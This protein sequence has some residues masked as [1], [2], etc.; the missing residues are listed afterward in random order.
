MGWSG[1]SLVKRDTMTAV[2][3]NLF[4][5]SCS[6][7]TWKDVIGCEEL[8]MKPATP[9]ILTFRLER[10]RCRPCASHSDTKD[11]VEPE[12]RI[13]LAS[14]VEPLEDCTKTRQVISRRSDRIPIVA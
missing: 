13:A 5:G 6:D 1:K 11:A 7:D 3:E 9:E 10:G 2:T 14:M 4:R 8:R 12:S